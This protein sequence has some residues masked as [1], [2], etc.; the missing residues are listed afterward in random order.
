VALGNLYNRKGEIDMKRKKELENIIA[1]ASQELSEI[2]E[3]ESY[4]RGIQYVGKYQKIRNNYSCPEEESD[5]WW[6]YRMIFKI[7]EENNLKHFEFQ[8][9]SYGQIF[10]KQDEYARIYDGWI[11][12]SADEFWEQWESLQR[13]INQIS[14]HL[15]P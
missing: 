15:M 11:D 3:K 10:I 13:E 12:I 4:D 8:K 6:L 9:D 2:Q 7:D 14:L 1:Q 5:Y